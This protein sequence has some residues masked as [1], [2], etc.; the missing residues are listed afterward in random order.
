SITVTP[1]A[2]SAPLYSIASHKATLREIDPASGAT[3]PSVGLTLAG[4]TVY[5]GNGVA[6]DPISGQ[7]YAVIRRGSDDHR[8]LVTVD[9]NSGVCTL[10]G[11]TEVDGH[12]LTD[13]TFDDA[14][15]LWGIT[16]NGGANRRSLV[17]IDKS[18]GAV[19]FKLFL[20]LPRGG[21][22]ALGFNPDDGLLYTLRGEG[23]PNEDE[24]LDTI[25]PT[26]LVTTNVPLSG[27]DYAGIHSMTYDESAGDFVFGDNSY[28]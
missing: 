16:G 18:S 23:A 28:P 25:H 11:D 20:G 1:M 17:T 26:T 21:G 24:L 12:L 3:L 10:I 13:I 9:P 19:S 7:L 27:F 8:V 15:R 5:G 4:E 6:V 14:G 22:L 2:F